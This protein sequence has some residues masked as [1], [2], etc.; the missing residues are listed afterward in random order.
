MKVSRMPRNLIYTAQT[1]PEARRLAGQLKDGGYTA[2]KVGVLRDSRPAGG[3]V[4]YSVSA[5]R[6]GR[7][8][9][10]K[11]IT[12]ASIRERIR[13]SSAKRRIA[14]AL[15]KYLKQQNPGQKVSAVRVQKLKGGVIKITPV[16]V[17]VKR[18]K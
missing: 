6:P 18:T 8:N 2:V 9:P 10:V 17:A 5:D 15:A 11:K 3:G 14:T 7:S 1:K 4:Y 13:K 12:K 16:K